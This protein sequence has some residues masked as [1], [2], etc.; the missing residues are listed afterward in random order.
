M[1]DIHEGFVS[2]QAARQSVRQG[3][4]EHA[5]GR[6]L[7]ERTRKFSKCSPPLGKILLQTHQTQPVWKPDLTLFTGLPSDLTCDW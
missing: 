4:R 1:W 6:E 5:L 3:H 7:L 2:P